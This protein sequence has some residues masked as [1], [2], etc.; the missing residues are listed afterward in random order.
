MEVNDD[1]QRREMRKE[2]LGIFAVIMLVG[3][4]FC[5]VKSGFKED[6]IYS[7]GLSNSQYMPFLTELFEDGEGV[8][9]R[10]QLWN[11]ITVNDGDSFDYGSVYYNQTQ[12]VHP[13]L[14]YFLLHTICSVFPETFNK[15]M[16]LSLNLF[17]FAG[18]L[19]LLYNV[20][21]RLLEGA[22]GTGSGHMLSAH[23]AGLMAMVLYGLSMAGLSE[24]VLIRM[25]MLA[26]FLNVLLVWWIL[27][28]LRK[29]SISLYLAL[30][31][32]IFAGLTTHY[33]FVFYA[34]FACAM[35]DIYYLTTKKGRAF[36]AV[37]VAAVLG[38][39]CMYL[40][41]PAGLEDLM[42]GEKVTGEGFVDKVTSLHSI[43]SAI[44]ITCRIIVTDLAV[45]SVAGI[46][47]CCLLFK[48]R[49]RLK[50]QMTAG[51][52]MEMAVLVVPAVL[53]FMAVSLLTPSLR[54][55]YNAIP[56]VPVAAACVWY[57]VMAAEDCE[58]GEA[59]A[60]GRMCRLDSKKTANGAIAVMIACSVGML[61][62]V[63]PEHLY[64]DHKQYNEALTTVEGA[65]V[66]YYTDVY[67]PSI[68]SDVV[69]ML[70]FPD[71]YISKEAVTDGLI[72]YVKEHQASQNM[73]VFFAKYP[74]M[75]D[76]EA[77]LTSLNDV[78]GGR[79]EPELL[80]DAKQ[81]RTYLMR[82]K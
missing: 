69:Q 53:D 13:P 29:Q 46:A 57:W 40:Y 12:D 54:Y 68:T 43:A 15:W 11:Y 75:F 47:G 66:V 78:L 17:L 44:F 27:C 41:Y 81:S 2:F 77:Y 73:V 72:S 50:G 79:Y 55:I 67:H 19:L 42:S 37:S 20:M 39:L 38:V 49:K 61:F 33:Y 1:V 60:T 32:T 14:Y 34:F 4:F 23:K 51:R 80:Y 52:V 64:R 10:Q 7:Y 76:D 18:T 35:L 25:Y 63:E 24:L 5:T 62:L 30:G 59:K 82:M 28:L 16:G 58:T 8:I 26:S 22:K 74:E 31:V 6:E 21:I 65:P 36:A 70:M 48:Q 9:N 45:T 71:A 56:L 3:I